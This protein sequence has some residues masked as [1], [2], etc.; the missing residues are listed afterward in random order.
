MGMTCSSGGDAE[1][2][3]KMHGAGHARAGVLPRTPRGRE[4]REAAPRGK[5]ASPT[6]SPRAP[7]TLVA[8]DAVFEPPMSIS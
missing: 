3:G 4:R 6:A 8:L 5:N 7:D 2:H 1:R